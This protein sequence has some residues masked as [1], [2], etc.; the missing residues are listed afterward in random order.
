MDCR[1]VG[2]ADSS[3][4]PAEEERERAADDEEVSF[5]FQVGDFAAFA[6]FFIHKTDFGAV[7][8]FFFV[9]SDLRVLDRLNVMETPRTGSSWH[10]CVEIELTD[11]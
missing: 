7:Y 10:H 3:R 2:G 8:A 6:I 4:S 5:I 11:L 9:F 1:S